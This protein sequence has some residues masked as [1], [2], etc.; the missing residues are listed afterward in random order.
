[1]VNV[2]QIEQT[3]KYYSNEV[4]VVLVN[5]QP[6]FV[7]KDVCY[8][9]GIEKSRNAVSRLDEDEAL[10]MGITDSLGRTQESHIISEAG[11][12]TLILTS[13]KPEAK[14]FK[15]WITHEVLPSIRQNGHYMLPSQ[16]QQ[17]K[18]PMTYKE[19]LVELV[20]KV[21]ENEQLQQTISEQQPKVEM[22][23]TLMSAE[24]Y[25]NMS[26]VAKSLEWGRTRL[27]SFLREEKIL[28]DSSCPYKRNLPHQQYIDSGYFKVI[29]VPVR[30]S[31]GIGISQQTL[32]TPKGV[33]FIA[34]LVKRKW[35]YSTFKESKKPKM[36]VYTMNATYKSIY[37]CRYD[38]TKEECQWLLTDDMTYAKSFNSEIQLASIAD[39][40]D[41]VAA[42]GETFNGILSVKEGECKWFSKIVVDEYGD[43]DI[44]AVYQLLEPSHM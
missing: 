43:Q 31:S 26:Q 21:E 23:D 33:E 5:D 34:R 19:A 30:S 24:G 15:R 41:W 38:F 17:F 18:L 14:A 27:Y 12:Y 29:D 4:R 6:W 36:Q 10:T 40:H 16:S 35:N 42:T 22:Y 37:I 20:S 32:A 1:M 9:L 2:N 44:I 39:L 8:I 3:F 25:Q 13:R 7:A 11:L 28:I